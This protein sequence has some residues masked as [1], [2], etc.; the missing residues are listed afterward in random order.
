[1]SVAVT[2]AELIVA[3]TL[4]APFNALMS[5]CSV[6]AEINVPRLSVLTVYVFCVPESA[7]GPSERM[8]MCCPITALVAS[9]PA[10]ADPDDK[11]AVSEAIVLIKSTV[12]EDVATPSSSILVPCTKFCFVAMILYLLYSYVPIISVLLVA[13]T[14]PFCPVTALRA[15]CNVAVELPPVVSVKVNA[16]PAPAGAPTNIS[17]PSEI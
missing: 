10:T 16:P 7:N 14:A 5:A 11:S 8:L 13:V 4:P 2:V 3:V 9:K 17:E 15:V 6:P 12:K 1:M